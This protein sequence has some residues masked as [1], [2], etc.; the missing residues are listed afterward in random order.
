VKNNQVG[1]TYLRNGKENLA[2]VPIHVCVQ[3][4]SVVN[5]EGNATQ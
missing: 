1:E 5:T 4:T 3:L 2:R